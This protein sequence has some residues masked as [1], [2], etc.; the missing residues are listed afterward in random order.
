MRIPLQIAEAEWDEVLSIIDKES[1]AF[2]NE[3][4][5]CAYV[6]SDDEIKRL[7][8]DE[9]LEQFLAISKAIKYPLKEYDV[10]MSQLFGAEDE[11]EEMGRLMQCWITL[12]SS[13]E[14]AF[15]ICLAVYLYDY[16]KSDWGKWNNFNYDKVKEGIYNALNELE[17]KKQ[18]EKPE[19]KSLKKAIKEHL[20]SKQEVTSLENLNLQNLIAFF[21]INLSWDND[22]ITELNKIRNYRNCVHAF[23]KRDIGLWEELLY[24]LKFYCVLLLDLQGMMPDVDDMIS[25]MIEAQR[26]YESDYRDYYSDY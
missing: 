11:T 1:E 20:K 25:N 4:K 3:V 14:S 24:S 19:A 23:K 5:K 17:Q 18:I 7:L 13:V 26:K 21:E 16:E 15:Q 9:N 2:I 12:G 22:Y 8:A 6:T 10:D